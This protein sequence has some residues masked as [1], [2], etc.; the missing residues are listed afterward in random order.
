MAQYKIS[1][2][3]FICCT[4]SLVHTCGKLTWTPN[5]P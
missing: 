4:I 1:R 5:K 3:L 2:V